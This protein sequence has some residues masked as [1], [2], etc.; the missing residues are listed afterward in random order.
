MVI[1]IISII[2]GIIVFIASLASDIPTVNQ[3][4]VQHLDFI[5][6]SLFV[7][8]GFIMITIKRCLSSNTTPITE[9][10][11]NEVETWK[12]K[13]CGTPNLSTE[14]LCTNCKNYK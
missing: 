6:T 3:Q 10:Q 4:I 12:C 11:K 9:K 8:G 13:I 1:G 7:V 14:V 5:W 2:I